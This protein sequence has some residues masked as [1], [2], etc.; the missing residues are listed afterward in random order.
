MFRFTMPHKHAES[1]FPGTIDE[2]LSCEV[3]SYV[4]IQSE[5][6]DIPIA[7]LHGFGF[8][9]HRHVSKNLEYYLHRLGN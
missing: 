4:W 7:F 1:R 2:K 6:S 9:D 5:C 3:G 8:S